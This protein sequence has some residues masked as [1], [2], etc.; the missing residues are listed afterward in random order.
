[1]KPLRLC[2]VGPATSITFRRWVRW[3]AERGHET[4][5]LTVEPAEASELAGLRQI[6]LG[7]ARGDGKLARLVS[8]G[9]LA[10]LLRRLKPDVVHVHYLRGLAWG[11]L[12]AR[13][14]PCVVSPWGS[15]V[16]ADQGAFREWYSRMLTRAVLRSADL[17]T[18]HSGYLE[19][20]IRSLVRS[21][22]RLARIG[23]GVNLSRFRPG[24]DVQP[25]RE[26]WGI[27]EGQRVIFSPRLAQPFYKH[28]L[29]IAALPEILEKVP[30]AQLVIPEQ[31]ADGQYVAALKRR[32]SELDV[33]EHVRFV[34]SIP[35]EEMPLWYNLAEIAVMVP[36][37]D[38]MPNSLLE[39]MA[40]GAVP[41]MSKL[42]QYAE[43]IHHGR[44]GFLVD[45]QGHELADSISLALS[46]AELRKDIAE[47]NAALVKEIG[48]QDHEMALMEGWYRD[49]VASSGAAG[50]GRDDVWN[51]RHR[52]A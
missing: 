27:S 6:T 41:V 30:Q 19:A 51:S 37:S 28:D 31:C 29:V 35:Y 36:A 13:C 44:N 5:I 17:V 24:L 25:L 40:C 14:Q 34:G 9:R 18:V 52:A 49:L 42:P 38:G 26:R 32:A 23:R 15:D 2:Y 1:M 16:L 39:A 33:A 4:T 45:P 22:V 12:L 10:V 21:P 7:A 48:D 20:T 43:V 8:A 46:Q 47:R 11:L 3:F 50:I